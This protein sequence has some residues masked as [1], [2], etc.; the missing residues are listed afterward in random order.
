MIKMPQS[1]AD[2]V[3]DTTRSFAFL[4]TTMP[5]GSPQVTPVWFNYRDGYLY[6]NTAAGRV[7]DRNMLERPIIAVAIPDPDNAYRY[8]QIRGH[9]VERTL[10]GAAEHID[11]LS[12]KYKGTPY[13][14]PAGQQRVIYR[15]EPDSLTT[16]G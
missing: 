4:A 6:I 16:N 12:H 15:I 14:L 2:L 13:N 9:V 1:H 11:W 5:D 3:A 7:K 8:L 10:E